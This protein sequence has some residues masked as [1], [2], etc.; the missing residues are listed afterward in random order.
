MASAVTSRFGIWYST[1]PSPLREMRITRPPGS[2][3]AIRLP[4]RSSASERTWVSSLLKKTAPLPSGAT[5]D[6]ALIAGR[7]EQ[8]ACGIA[9]HR[10]DVLLFGVVEDFASCRSHRRDRSCRR[11]PSRHR[12]DPSNRSRW[13]GF[14]ARRTRRSSRALPFGANAE[15]LGAGTAAGIEVAVRI[16]RQRPEIGGRRVEDLAC[17]RRE[18]EASVAAQREVFQIAL[19]EIG[20]IGLSPGAGFAGADRAP[21]AAGNRI[22]FQTRLCNWCYF[23]VTRSE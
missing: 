18:R 9:H 15:E 14:R 17:L 16:A 5:V 3:P 8:V 11:A 1:K 10:P 23:T 13:R 22:S 12:R 4:S 2:V 20:V 7:D 19:L 21:R 6:L